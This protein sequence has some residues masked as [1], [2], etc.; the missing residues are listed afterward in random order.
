MSQPQIKTDIEARVKD[1]GDIMTG[2]LLIS[3][4]NY[5]QLSFNNLFN[6]R[7]GLIQMGENGEL[8]VLTQITNDDNNK[9]VLQ[10]SEENSSLEDLLKIITVKDGISTSYRVYHEGFKPS[11]A[12]ES[13]IDNAI[14]RYDLEKQGLQDS[15]IIITDNNDIIINSEI[16]LSYDSS[17]KSLNFIFN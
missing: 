1:T 12:L 3:T 17:N 13:Q 4:E 5:P 10:I 6:S 16:T 2:N 11:A 14:I 7:T 8:I 9:T 15:N